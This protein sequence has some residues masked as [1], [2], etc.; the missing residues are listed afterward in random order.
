METHVPPDA[1]HGPPIGATGI[2]PVMLSADRFPWQTTS[3][4]T[5]IDFPFSA[6]ML[7]VKVD[8]T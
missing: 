5:S 3:H 6:L 2:P 4:Q 8:P 1:P 7:F